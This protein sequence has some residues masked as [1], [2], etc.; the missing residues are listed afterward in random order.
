MSSLLDSLM[1]NMKMEDS[2]PAVSEVSG[3]VQNAALITETDLHGLVRTFL[4][5]FRWFR[6]KTVINPFVGIFG[7]H[8]CQ[9]AG[10]RCA[11]HWRWHTLLKSGYLNCDMRGEYI[12]FVIQ[13]TIITL[14]TITTKS[15][16]SRWKVLIECLRFH[17][18]TSSV[19]GFTT[20]LFYLLFYQRGHSACA[21]SS[22]PLYRLVFLMALDKIPFCL[23]LWKG[24]FQK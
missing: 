24:Y 14:T 20:I 2:P 9:Q 13:L 23:D 8:Y 11:G 10:I 7:F 15:R 19:F 4:I 1:N 21:V 5:L 3:L 6:M 22:L 17:L 18:K 16:C 12:H